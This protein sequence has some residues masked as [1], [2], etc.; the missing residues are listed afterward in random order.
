[1]ADPKTKSAALRRL[2][3][4]LARYRRIMDLAA[5]V[6]AERG[7]EYLAAYDAGL[8]YREIAEEASVTD[9]AVMQKAKRARQLAAK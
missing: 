3:R 1:M 6:E 8:T 2:R 7:S 9:S 4:F 5:E